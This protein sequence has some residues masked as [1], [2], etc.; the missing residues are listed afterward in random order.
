MT[1]RGVYLKHGRRYQEISGKADPKPGLCRNLGCWSRIDVGTAGHDE[2]I[3]RVAPNLA[4]G[5]ASGY[6]AMLK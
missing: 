6:K 2:T 4:T 5:V 1:R 3:E